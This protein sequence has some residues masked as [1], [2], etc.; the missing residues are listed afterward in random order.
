MSSSVLQRAKR[1]LWKRVGA[2]KIDFCSF[3]LTAEKQLPPH[4]PHCHIWS[5]APKQRLVWANEGLFPP[6]TSVSLAE[7]AV[8]Q[9]GP[10]TQWAPQF[11]CVFLPPRCWDCNGV[12]TA[13]EGRAP[14][15]HSPSSL[16]EQAFVMI[17][18]DSS[19]GMAWGP[20]IVFTLIFTCERC[21]P[22]PQL[23]EFL[24][25]W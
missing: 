13:E 25:R 22:T 23:G 21:S 8:N 15:R 4:T 7:E 20:V 3:S 16:Q 1:N 12:F 11:A 19:V 14:L 5:R 9:C 18:H 10:K 2:G 17:P 6:G 24:N